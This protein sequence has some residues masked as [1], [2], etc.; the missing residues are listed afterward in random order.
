M[1]ARGLQRAGHR[2]VA[3][4]EIEKHCQAVLT[5]R[6]PGRPVYDDVRTLT[7]A[8]LEA[9]GVVPDALCGGFPCQDLSIAGH[10]AGIDGARSGL[11]S[12]VIRLADE[13]RPRRIVL[14]NV[15]NLLAGDDGRWFG[16]VLGDLAT[17]GYDAWWDC[18]PAS[19]VGADHVR[20]RT[21][22]VAYPQR[23]G[24]QG[25][26]VAAAVEPEV[27]RAEQLPRLL[28]L[29]LGDAVS[30]ARV[31]RADHGAPSRLDVAR[32]KAVGNG[33]VDRIPEAIGR[34][35]A[36]LDAGGLRAAA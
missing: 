23:D 5:E 17:L 26:Q 19:A 3:F 28:Q 15:T 10:T 6:F 7:A 35:L 14:E 1:F 12:E 22:I 29:G 25:W 4:C 9:D 33:L 31:W 11:F 16:R 20:D 2:T 34:A 24:L 27:R 8:R 21:W 30:A 13:V 36:T 32:N 18:V